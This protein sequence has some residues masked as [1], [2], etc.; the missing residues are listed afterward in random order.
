VPPTTRPLGQFELWAS[1]CSQR[2]P[3]IE[4]GRSISM[5]TDRPR[6]S[7]R[8]RNRQS[9]VI[10]ITASSGLAD[11]E[12]EDGQGC[13]AHAADDKKRGGGG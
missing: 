10:K 12:S 5:P 6:F 1:L 2:V 3:Q 7:Q 9:A 4:Y 13:E 11:E 8:P